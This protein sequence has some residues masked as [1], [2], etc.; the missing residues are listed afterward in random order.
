MRGE[1]RGSQRPQAEPTG[2]FRGPS[3]FRELKRQ[4]V[5]E[6]V[7]VVVLLAITGWPPDLGREWWALLAFAAFT[8]LLMAAA[9]PTIVTTARWDETGVEFRWL[10]GGPSF[11]LW[12][13]LERLAR[14]SRWQGSDGTGALL[15]TRWREVI[16][17]SSRGENYSAF[18]AALRARLPVARDRDGL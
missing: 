7:A 10:L 4:A 11:Y 14:P 5:Y 12:D 9:G 17:I 1:E 2:V 3:P 16:E 15:F 8:G 18:V 6:A 13:E